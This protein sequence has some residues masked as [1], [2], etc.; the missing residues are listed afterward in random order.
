M[1][2]WSQCHLLYFR[3]ILVSAKKLEVLNLEGN[4]GSF[5]TDTFFNTI[6]S[7]NSLPALT[8]LDISF[9]DQVESICN[10]SPS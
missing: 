9:N 4:F 2:I 3:S 6:L 8:T 7:R 1:N 5:L 10:I